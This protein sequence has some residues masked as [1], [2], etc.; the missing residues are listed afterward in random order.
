MAFR[1]RGVLAAAALATLITAVPVTMGFRSGADSAL[2]GGAA[3][4]GANCTTCHDFN[5][6]PG[7]VDVVGLPRRYRVGATYEFGIHIFDPEQKGA[8][9]ELSAEGGGFHLGT[10]LIAN[11]TTTWFADFDTATDYI[12]HTHEGVDASIATWSTGDGGYTYDVGWQAPMVDAGPVTF[13]AA[14]NGWLR[15][16]LSGRPSNR[17]GIGAR[18]IVRTEEGELGRTVQTAAGY[19]GS[20]DPTLGFG[21][22]RAQRAE[23]EVRWPS[24]QVDRLDAVEAGSLIVVAEGRGVVAA[25]RLTR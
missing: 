1:F 11:A 13:F 9:F 6:G 16:R 22:G 5:Q 17:D 25:R 14:G 23:V 7:G 12:T 20:N 3:A 21:L 19:L 15:V 2:S 8:G 4:F 24:G 10:L 18:V